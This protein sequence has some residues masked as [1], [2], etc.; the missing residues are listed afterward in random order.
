MILMRDCSGSS[1]GVDIF[2]FQGEFENIDLFD[3][4]FDA[5]TLQMRFKSFFLQGRKIHREL[6][7]CEKDDGKF[8]TLGHVS[9]VILFDSP[10]RYDTSKITKK[11]TSLGK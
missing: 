10:P 7:I 11:F 2:E 3:A 5:K 6:T 1:T 9:E 8:S 4:E